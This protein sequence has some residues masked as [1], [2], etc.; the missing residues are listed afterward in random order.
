MELELS[1]AQL[2]VPRNVN[3]ERFNCLLRAA[4][5]FWLRDM[6]PDEGLYITFPDKV[7]M[8]LKNTVSN[9]KQE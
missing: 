7:A 5:L 6:I 4:D 3:D 1:L 2:Q 8:H 9:Q